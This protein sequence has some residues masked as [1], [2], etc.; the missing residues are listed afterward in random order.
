MGWQLEVSWGIGTKGLQLGTGG[1]KQE[2][3]QGISDSLGPLSAP[4]LGVPVR[5]LPRRGGSNL[6]GAWRGTEADPLGKTGFGW[7]RAPLARGP[8]SRHSCPWERPLRWICAGPG[9]IPWASF[10]MRGK[11]NVSG[12]PSPPAC[13]GSPWWEEPGFSSAGSS[14][15]GFDSGSGSSWPLCSPHFHKGLEQI[16]LSA[17]LVFD[18]RH[19]IYWQ[20]RCNPTPLT[21]GHCFHQNSGVMG[22]GMGNFVFLGKVRRDPLPP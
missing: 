9:E 18:G 5:P 8:G 10:M 15:F 17:E 21:D 14:C 3:A 11:C 4:N 7:G 12:S 22:W 20:D 16:P 13:P 19:I 6:K 2:R 1:Q